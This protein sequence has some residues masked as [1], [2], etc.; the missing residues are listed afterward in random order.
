M[1]KKKAPARRDL[2][3]SHLFFLKDIIVPV[4]A[5]LGRNRKNNIQKR[6]PTVSL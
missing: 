4:S 2:L 1:N 6:K 5:P 3:F